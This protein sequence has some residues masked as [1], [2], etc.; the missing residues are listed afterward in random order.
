MCVDVCEYV[1]IQVCA[2]VCASV[3]VHVHMH[4]YNGVGV[5]LCLIVQCSLA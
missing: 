3:C 4:E 1:Q 2:S 5:R